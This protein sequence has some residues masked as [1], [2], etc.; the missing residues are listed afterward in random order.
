M[1]S[2]LD[3]NASLRA[4]RSATTGTEQLTYIEVTLDVHLSRP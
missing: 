4:R 2:D 1:R 3:V